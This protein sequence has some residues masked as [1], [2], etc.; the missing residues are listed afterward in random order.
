MERE[1]YNIEMMDNRSGWRPPQIDTQQKKFKIK[2][3]GED[4]GPKNQVA[5]LNDAKQ[6]D[7]MDIDLGPQQPRSTRS[8]THNRAQSGNNNEKHKTM[9]MDDIKNKQYGLV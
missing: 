1:L 5:Q 3:E 4:D 2:K 8:I 9:L 6:S 7:G